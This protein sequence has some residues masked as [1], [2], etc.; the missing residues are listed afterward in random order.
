MSVT[1]ITAANLTNTETIGQL[2]TIAD[3]ISEN[4]LFA[5]IVMAVFIIML[6]RNLKEGPEAAI[7]SAA[8]YC[9]VISVVLLPLGLINV[10]MPIIF[11]VMLAAVAFYNYMN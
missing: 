1:N 7:G 4:W 6:V 9:L 11:G 8:F 5:L 3:R 2:L 10:S